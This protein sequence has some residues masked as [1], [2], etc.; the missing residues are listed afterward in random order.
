MEKTHSGFVIVKNHLYQNLAALSPMELNINNLTFPPQE[1]QR[2]DS[3]TVAMER[4]FADKYEPASFQ[5]LILRSQLLVL[6]HYKAF[7]NTDYV[8]PHEDMIRFY[9]KGLNSSTLTVSLVV[10]KL[11]PFKFKLITIH[12]QKT[13]VNRNKFVCIIRNSY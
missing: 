2:S 13:L 10:N 3:I 5:G 1:I 8:I 9:P 4:S 11:F 7:D 12:I 6:L